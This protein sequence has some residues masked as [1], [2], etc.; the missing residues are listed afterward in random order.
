MRDLNTLQCKASPCGHH[1]GVYAA[2]V[3]EHPLLWLAAETEYVRS[4]TG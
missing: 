4:S 2:V 1:I 3:L